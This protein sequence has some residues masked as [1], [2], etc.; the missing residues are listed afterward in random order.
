MDSILMAMVQDN[1]FWRAEEA[2]ISC[3]LSLLPSK[4][5]PTRNWPTKRRSCN[6]FSSRRTIAERRF[7]YVDGRN[8]LVCEGLSNWVGITGYCVYSSAGRFEFADC[9]LFVGTAAGISGCERQRCRCGDNVPGRRDGVHG[10]LS[11]T[12]GVHR[13]R[14]SLCGSVD[15][16]QREMDA[17]SQGLG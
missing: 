16:L 3:L 10:D 7:T 8:K 5:P 15:H 2:E 9:G 17:P 14:R 4:S 11:Q 1:T 13:S 12:L 6:C